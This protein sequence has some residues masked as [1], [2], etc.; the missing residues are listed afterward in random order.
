MEALENPA[1]VIVGTV[2]ISRSLQLSPDSPT[3]AVLVHTY[4]PFAIL[5]CPGSHAP[6]SPAVCYSK[7]KF[8]KIPPRMHGTST[9]C[10]DEEPRET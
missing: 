3:P 8:G 2:N 7:F 6:S 4:C 9:V 1:N 10:Y 5:R